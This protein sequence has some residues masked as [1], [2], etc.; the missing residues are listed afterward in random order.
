MHIQRNNRNNNIEK[1]TYLSFDLA[2]SIVD[3]KRFL[4]GSYCR[5]L[6]SHRIR[7]VRKSAILDSSTIL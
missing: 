5:S 7:I 6:C 3:D 2:V 4:S 1:V